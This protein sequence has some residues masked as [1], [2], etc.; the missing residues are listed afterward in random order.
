M[1]L[2]LDVNV[3][4]A[5][6]RTDHPQYDPVRTWLESL[7]AA[8]SDFGVPRFVW[9]SFL[10]LATHRRVFVVPTPLGDAFDFVD[11][12]TAQPGHVA[13]EPGARHLALVRQLCLEADASGDLIPDAVLAAVAVEHG[14]AVATLDRDF[15]RF[16]S[17]RRVRPG[18]PGDARAEVS[19]GGCS[20][21]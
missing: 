20:E 11:A 18:D 2:V 16:E 4:L 8:R 5:A 3:L 9:A 10:R 12:I 21:A 7:L 1:M 14:A 17:V 6:H 13:A 15:A 19:A